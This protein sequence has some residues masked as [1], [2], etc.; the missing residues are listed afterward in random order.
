MIE[1]IVLVH[2]GVAD[3]RMWARQAELLRGRGYEVLTPDLP[4]FGETP[5]PG[6]PFADRDTITRLLPAT[7]VGNSFGGRVA[8][9]AAL[10][11]PEAVPRLV[12]VAPALREH[13]WSQ[14]LR[15]YGAREDE[16]VDAGDLDGATELTLETF[17]QPH[18]R[19]FVR[20]MQRRA[21]ELQVAAPEIKTRSPESRP[22]SAL[23]MPTLVVVGDRDRPDFRTIAERIVDE[24]PHARLEVIAG[25]GHLP[26]LETPEAFDEL[27]VAF[28]DEP[29][30]RLRSEGVDRGAAEHDDA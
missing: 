11:R 25:A 7:L 13:E 5:L 6:E 20:P 16:L 21:Y 8:V 18:V 29:E 14:E 30:E 26:S 19:A 10:A 17:V 2:A 28:L 3:S 23:T 27:L 24:A 22:L 4:G 1:R 12:L 15:A 9:E